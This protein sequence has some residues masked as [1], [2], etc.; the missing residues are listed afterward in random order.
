MKSTWLCLA[1]FFLFCSSLSLNAQEGFKFEANV[2][3]PLADSGD[4]YSFALQG[5]FYYSWQVS[6]KI[7]IGP[8]IGIIYLFEEDFPESFDS[9]PAFY[10]PIAASGRVKLNTNWA[11]GFD[12]GYAIDGN[13]GTYFGSA[14]EEDSTGGIYLRPV[15]GYYFKEKLALIA[16]YAHINQ[17]HYKAASLS[18]GVN[19]WF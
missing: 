17:K 14:F 2:G 13:L 4:F 11:A 19:F 15:I 8:T 7:Y 6:D 18:L 10:I 12:L 3:V 5:N 1:V 16:S 9:L